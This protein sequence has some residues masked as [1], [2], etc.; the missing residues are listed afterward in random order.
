[1]PLFTKL[2]HPHKRFPHNEIFKRINGVSTPVVKHLTYATVPHKLKAKRD[3]LDQSLLALL[4]PYAII[5][6]FALWGALQMHL[7]R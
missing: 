7:Y 4:F 3:W 1:M 6:L 2:C 5:F